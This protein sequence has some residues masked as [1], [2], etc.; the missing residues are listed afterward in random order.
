M[1]RLAIVR[2]HECHPDSCENLC[3]KICPI[4]R[5]GEDCIKIIGK[6][7]I[8]EELCIGCGICQNRCPFSAISIVN[9]PDELLKKL[10]YRYGDNGFAL[11]SLPMIRFGSVLGL[12]G[13]NGIGKSTALEILGNKLTPNLGKKSAERQEILDFF[14]GSEMF[15]YF[16][17]ISNFKIAIKP[18]NIS[19]LA[20]YKIPVIQFLTRFAK[21]SEAELLAEE[22]AID[23]LIEKNLDELSG[24]ELQK[25]AIL[26][27]T[28]KDA[29]VYFMDEPLAFLDI[30][31]R[32]RAVSYTHLTLPTI[33]SV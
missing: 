8:S 19:E 4:N 23:H 18:Q 7:S 11:Y 1:K 9:L 29:D 30:V 26:A 14:K 10:V 28:L 24:G 33:Y 2:K 21:A 31:E 16:E 20:K 3:A 27:A 15:N 25:V 32:I 12:L 5:K 6:A 22:L 13:K 17:N